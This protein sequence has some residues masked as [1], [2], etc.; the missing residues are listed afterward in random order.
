MMYTAIKPS[1][2]NAIRLIFS[3]V[4]QAIDFTLENGLSS[5]RPAWNDYVG[6][7]M[8]FNQENAVVSPANSFRSFTIGARDPVRRG[9]SGP[10]FSGNKASARTMRPF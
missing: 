5:L 7:G 1:V 3:P 4:W 9:S 6:F 10:G 2:Q 8:A